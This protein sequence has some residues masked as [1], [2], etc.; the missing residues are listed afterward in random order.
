[1]HFALN[2]LINVQVS[3]DFVGGNVCTPLPLQGR[4][5]L[6]KELFPWRASLDR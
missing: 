3:D 1:M 2:N 5:S 6:A 4:D